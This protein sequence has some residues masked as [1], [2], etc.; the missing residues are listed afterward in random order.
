MQSG[1]SHC[2]AQELGKRIG[3]RR[4]ALAWTQAQLAERMGCDAETIS[5]FERGVNLPSITTLQLMCEALCCRASDLL[6]QDHDSTTRL[7]DLEMISIWM[8]PLTEHERQFVIS[9]VEVT[10]N[11]FSQ[12]KSRLAS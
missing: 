10:C 1:Y 7:G 5:R 2:L 9:Q 4:R 11:F 8:E 12:Q 3:E 6:D